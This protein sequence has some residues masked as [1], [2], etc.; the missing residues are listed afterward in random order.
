MLAIV[1]N[2][3]AVESARKVIV[4]VVDVNMNVTVI[5]VE[6]RSVHVKIVSVVKENEI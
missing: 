5:I 1:T 4:V 3:I 2:A 6:I